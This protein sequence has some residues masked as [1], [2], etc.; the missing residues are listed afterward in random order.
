ME[1]FGRLLYLHVCKSAQI[2]VQD[3]STLLKPAQKCSVPSEP[4]LCLYRN[5]QVHFQLKELSW[6][7][8]TS[9]Q[10][11]SSAPISVEGETSIVALPQISL[12]PS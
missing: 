10:T 2:V 5:R 8:V 4:S 6:I 7:Q 11:D 9:N 3:C 12:S 1:I